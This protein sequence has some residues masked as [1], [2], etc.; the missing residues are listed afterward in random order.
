MPL[1]ADAA[2]V[3]V[4][5]VNGGDSMAFSFSSPLLDG[6]LFYIENFDSNSSANIN[7]VGATSVSVLE[8]SPSISYFGAGAGGFL[9]SSNA[10]YDGEGDVIFSLEGPVSEITLDYQSGDGANGVIYTFAAND[11][12]DPKAVPE[13]AS[14][15]VMAGLFAL[16]GGMVMR[17]KKQNEK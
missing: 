12:V 13:P 4:G 17:R 6:T 15:V 1:P 16:G 14:A 5:R 10:G 9:A 11:W 8:S 7:F 2:G 3:V